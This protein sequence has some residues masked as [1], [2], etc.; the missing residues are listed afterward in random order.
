[1]T[2]AFLLNLGLFLITQLL[3]QLAMRYGSDGTQA[4]QSQRWWLG[5]AL[6]NGVGIISMLFLKK[7]YAALPATPNVVA[8]LALAGTFL[9]TQL[10]F[11]A[12]GRARLSSVQWIG[13][14]LLAVGGGLAT[15]GG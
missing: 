6:A 13:I 1:M 7:L 3:A 14:C 2:G 11:W 8:V 10:F 4:L 9:L 15:M 5:F 12:C